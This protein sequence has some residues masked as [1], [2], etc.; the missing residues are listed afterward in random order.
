MRMSIRIISSHRFRLYGMAKSKVELPSL[1]MV[2]FLTSN[3]IVG[4]FDPI[5]ISVPKEV[6]III[7]ACGSLFFIYVLFYLRSGFL[8]ETEPKLDVLI[9]SGPYRFCRHPQYL[10]FIIMLFGMDFLSKR[11]RYSF[12]SWIIDSQHHLQGSN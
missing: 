6:A 2:L 10:S 7:F 8:G 1:F 5:K 11:H 3:L 12:Y 4:L 9:T